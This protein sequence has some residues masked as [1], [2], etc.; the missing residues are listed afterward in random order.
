MRP[1]ARVSASV[2]TTPERKNGTVIASV[3]AP[4]ETIAI[5]PAEPSDGSGTTSVTTCEIGIAIA[6]Q[7]AVRA[8]A[9]R[10]FAPSKRAPPRNT[11][12]APAAMPSIASE[13][14]KNDRWYQVSTE[15]RRESRISTSSV[16]A[17]VRN[18]PSESQE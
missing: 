5:M 16:A 3:L 7:S 6:N 17:V 15:S 12:T 13:T 14:A 9:G 1:P 18:R 8:S 10:T 2:T 11:A 4:S